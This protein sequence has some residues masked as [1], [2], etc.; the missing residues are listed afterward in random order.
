M[1]LLPQ[2]TSYWRICCLNWGSGATVSR[3]LVRSGEAGFTMLRQGGGRRGQSG[4]AALVG[5]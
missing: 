3:G 5:F 4:A 1:I 2:T